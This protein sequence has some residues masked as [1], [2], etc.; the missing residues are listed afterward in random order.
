MYPVPCHMRNVAKKKNM[1]MEVKV[2]CLIRYIWF[3]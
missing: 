3:T 1:M 2:I